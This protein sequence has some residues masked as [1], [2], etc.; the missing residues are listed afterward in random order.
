[1]KKIDSH[2]EGF[3]FYIDLLGSIHIKSWD[4]KK[5][6]L[7]KNRHQ[8]KD[9]IWVHLPRLTLNHETI[10]KTCKKIG[11]G[12]KSFILYMNLPSLTH[13]MWKKEHAMQ[14]NRYWE[15]FNPY[16]DSPDSSQ[17]ISL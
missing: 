10:K 6:G 2:W 13:I 9:L 5:K 17:I 14:E 7:Q 16:M 12:W 3:I 15:N 8:V 11:T 1:M 4:Y